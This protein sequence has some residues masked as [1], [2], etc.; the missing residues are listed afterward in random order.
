[1][2]LQALAAAY[3]VM[4]SYEHQDGT[5]VTVPEETVR[6]VLE[7]MDV[8]AET[9][10]EVEVSLD[11]TCP[12][13]PRGWGFTAQLYATRSRASWGIGDYADL[14]RLAT[15]SAEEGA[16]FV[17]VNPLHAGRPGLPQTDSPYFPASRRF[18]EPL[19]LS[20][21]DLP[22]LG[23][24]DPDD[25]QRV[26]ALGDE[27]RALRG[28]VD[29]DAV[30]RLKDEALRLLFTVHRVHPHDE[31]TEQWARWCSGI[32]GQPPEYHAWLQFLCGEQLAEAQRE[33]REA[34]MAVGIVHDLA[35]GCDPDGFDAL[36]WRD[37]MARGVTIG[38]PP[39]EFNTKGQDWRLPPFRPDRLRATE[40][41]AFRDLLRANLT[42]AGGI[43]VDHAMGLFRLFW[44]P[45]G[46][47]PAEGTYVRYPADVMMRV[48]VEE[49]RRAGAI[50]IAEDLGTV[51]PGVSET[52]RA[53]G[54]LGSAVLWFEEDPPEDWPERTFASVTTHDLPTVA[55]KGLDPVETHALVARARSL[56]CGVALGDAVG[57]PTQPNVP[58]DDEH[59]SWRVPLPVLL[60]DLPD[61]P[62]LRRVVAA[63][64]EER[65]RQVAAG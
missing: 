5:V 2:S 26:L 49:C 22:E 9:D 45:D 7:A 1:M 19:Y 13:P 62:L 25:R 8:P 14:A 60:D 20:V 33:A 29:R 52:L 54:V 30:Y 61:H 32:D 46:M 21:E 43:R 16:S 44:I 4:T 64:S 37:D 63:V 34:G 12:L 42:D 48:L 11:E 50:A 23:L 17:L 41:A 35:V 28:L 53:H 56:L 55:A 6:R 3:G 59:P 10:A 58:G 47:S 31:A 27:A 40:G 36:L 39:D 38:A 15:W 24:L 57:D 51:E 65:A 18:R